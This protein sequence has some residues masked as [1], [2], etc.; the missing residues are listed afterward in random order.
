MIY[1]YNKLRGRIVEK[2]GNCEAFAKALGITN[3]TVSYKLNGKR[4]FS[5]DDILKWSQALEIAAEEIG[6]YFFDLNV[7]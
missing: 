5:Q 3:T 2:F 6:Y 1:R 7:Q 4:Q